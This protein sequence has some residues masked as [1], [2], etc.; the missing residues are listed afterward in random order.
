MSISGTS[1]ASPQ[2]CGLGALHLGVE[3]TLTPAQL[4]A[5]IIA[6]AKNVISNTGADNDYG[7]TTTSLMGA[8]NNMLFNRYNRQPY[9]TSGSISIKNTAIGFKSN[10]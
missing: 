5:K 3:P 4:K 9:T 2:V 1:M 6:D 7:N 10:G 8:S